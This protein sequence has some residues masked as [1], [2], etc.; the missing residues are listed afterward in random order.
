[1]RKCYISRDYP[2]VKNAGGKAKTDIEAIAQEMGMVN[3]GLRQTVGCS[4]PVHFVRNLWGAVLAALR[5]RKGDVLLLQ[6]PMKKYYTWMCKAAHR[7][8]ATVVTI[9]HDL[10]SFRRKALTVDQEIRRLNHSDAI[11]VHNPT[12]KQWLTSHGC[13]ARLTTLGIFDYLGSPS[14]Q[15]PAQSAQSHEA[16]TVNRVPRHSVF[17]VGSLHSKNNAFIYEL[18]T[19]IQRSHLYLYGNAYQ[20][21]LA[22]PETM[23]CMGFARDTDLMASCQGDYGLSW[24]GDSLEEGK[25]RIG[26]YMQY[27]NPHKVSLY[28]RCGVPV[29]LSKTAGLASF[30]QENGI[31]ICVDDLTD[32]D[33]V[34]DT[35]DATQYE[36]MRQNVA[37]VA[38]QIAS[39]HHFRS[40]YARCLAAGPLL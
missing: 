9:I 38:A 2:T 33:R 31:G 23:T 5:L 27:N 15:S 1:M 3:I 37:R 24:Y 40:A 16:S 10:G 26:E 18:G 12:M 30:V 17:F 35:V 21:E 6:Y 13:R 8:G 7:N 19:H 29:I 25:G 28:L 11:I 39:G 20:P 36:Q 32:L 34:L 14:A 22:N 4:K